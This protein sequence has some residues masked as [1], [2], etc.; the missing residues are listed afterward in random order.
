MTS[1]T[2]PQIS[3]TAPNT[4][5]NEQGSGVT[6]E[7]SLQQVNLAGV[8][9]KLKA[10][11]GN[12]FGE[13]YGGTLENPGNLREQ[14]LKA[15]DKQGEISGMVLIAQVADAYQHM[16]RPEKLSFFRMLARD[17][18][19]DQSRVSSAARAYLETE[20][21]RIEEIT[22]LKSVLESP[23][24]RL[25]R[26]FNTNSGGS[27]F[28]VD[29]R[30]DLLAELPKE[31]ELIGVE[32]DLRHLLITWFNIGVLRLE[33]LT[34]ETSA[35]TLEKL[36]EY[37]AVHQITS[38]DDLKRRLTSDRMAFA[39]FHPAMPGEPVIFLEA[40]MVKGLASSIQALLDPN[41]PTLAA[42][43]V[44][45][46]I[47]YSI[48]NAQKGLRGIPLGNFLIKQ[49]LA[50]LR[51]EFSHISTFATLSP[52]PN[53]RRGFLEPEL[54][55]GGLARFFQKAEVASLCAIT[56]QK[57]ISQALTAAL[58]VPVWNEEKN[59]EQAL[60]PGLLRA[61]R[62]YLTEVRK[63]DTSAACPVAH[64]HAS[65]GALLGR[66]NWLA[67]LST[68]GLRQS[69]GIMVN[70]VYDPKQFENAQ[71]AYVRKGML[72]LSKEVKNL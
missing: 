67:D 34:W 29:L 63:N 49:V 20:G 19:V 26:L 52:L 59:L 37:E 66:I 9:Y 15:L 51:T 5:P 54:V 10:A 12:W 25:F 30:A 61:V 41:R 4:P 7:T 2:K 24:L 56:G 68:K 47:F 33:R 35:E 23:R 3:N 27:K 58:N 17:L 31:P 69:M 1:E 11:F 57:N 64:F 46:A 53:F 14:C 48:S 36:I 55:S 13:R 65:N 71:A 60:R 43:Q 18:S 22:D 6:E 72:T 39:F 45:T 50:K 28:L 40:A 21:T 38:W 8:L 16:A 42:H 32:Y 70:Y 62:F 44:D